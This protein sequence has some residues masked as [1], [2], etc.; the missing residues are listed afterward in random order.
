MVGMQKAN[1]EHL[2]HL[3]AE[4]RKAN[5]KNKQEEHKVA[6]KFTKKWN[7]E[8]YEL[9]QEIYHQ[10]ELAVEESDEEEH[11]QLL[12]NKILMVTDHYGWETA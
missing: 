8:Q 4:I 9:N 2:K 3:K 10:M 11:G 12:R 1:S 7:G 5:K 6:F